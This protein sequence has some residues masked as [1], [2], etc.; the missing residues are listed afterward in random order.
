[1]FPAAGHLRLR[2]N[3]VVDFDFRQCCTVHSVEYSSYEGRKVENLGQNQMVQFCPFSSQ[4]NLLAKEMLTRIAKPSNR[5]QQPV[6]DSVFDCPEVG[7]E[8]ITLRGG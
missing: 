7:F 2:R 6:H 4:Q 1:L 3:T 8:E 5:K